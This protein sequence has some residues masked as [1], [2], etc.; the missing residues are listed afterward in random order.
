MSSYLARALDRFL[1]RTHPFA[2]VAALHHG[3]S[4]KPYEARNFAEL[5]GYRR[6]FDGFVAG[7]DEENISSSVLV[8]RDVILHVSARYSMPDNSLILQR[9]NYGCE[10]RTFTFEA[11]SWL[12]LMHP[13]SPQLKLFRLKCNFD[14]E[15]YRTRWTEL[16]RKF[17]IA[18][19]EG[20]FAHAYVDD[21]GRLLYACDAPENDVETSAQL[22]AEDF[23]FSPA[24]SEIR[25]VGRERTRAEMSDVVRRMQESIDYHQG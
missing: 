16:G 10:A 11:P 23:G 1:E 19:R 7:V 21:S 22:I 14:G 3:N 4:V 15:S 2:S 20:V 8:G 13:E 25:Q 12:S 9:E 5:G 17:T 18:G 24:P 6:D